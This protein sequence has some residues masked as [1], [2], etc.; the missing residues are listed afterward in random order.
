[1]KTFNS[2]VQYLSLV[3]LCF[4]TTVST[5]QVGAAAGFYTTGNPYTYSSTAASGNIAVVA[6]IKPNTNQ[7]RVSSYIVST[8]GAIAWKDNYDF[9]SASIVKVAM[10][11]DYRVVVARHVGTKLHM[12]TFDIHPTTGMLTKKDDFVSMHHSSNLAIVKLSNNSFATL[13][14]Q[15]DGNRISTFT[16]NTNG[17]ISIKSSLVFTG[18]AGHLDLARLSD[19]RFVAFMQGTGNHL[20]I[21]CLDVAANTYAITLRDTY[22]YS[23]SHKKVSLASFSSTRFTSFVIDANDR[24]DAKSYYVNAAGAITFFQDQNDIKKPG[25]NDFLLLKD[26]DAQTISTAPGIILLSA[27]RTN[28]NLCVIPFGFNNGYLALQGGG[29]YPNAPNVTQTSA[30]LINGNMMIGSFR[31]SSDGKYHIRS[32]KWD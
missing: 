4:A 7:I 29:Y 28:E 22:S 30:G 13:V 5:A 24:L 12:T 9:S 1:M 32:Y 8:T 15:L 31:Q 3:L 17:V 16:V 25:T 18:N 11:T 6:L 10:L 21:V 20:K 23:N 26:I 19:N 14:G 2:F 27:A